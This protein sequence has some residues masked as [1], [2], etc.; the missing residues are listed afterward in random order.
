MY[1]NVTKL[2]KK[3]VGIFKILLYQ[4]LLTFVSDYATIAS[5]LD[6]LRIKL[7]AKEEG[8]NK[9]K[10]KKPRTALLL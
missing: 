8:Y 6:T 9:W 4:N 2:C 5:F 10:K 3:K 1:Q 7:S